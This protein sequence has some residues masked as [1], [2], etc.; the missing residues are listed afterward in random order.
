MDC[1]VSLPCDDSKDGVWAQEELTGGH[2]GWGSLGWFPGGSKM[3]C[4]GTEQLMETVAYSPEVSRKHCLNSTEQRRQSGVG[5]ERGPTRTD[6]MKPNCS[7]GRATSKGLVPK[8]TWPPCPGSDLTSGKK[9]KKC[10]SQLFFCHSQAITVSVHR[11]AQGSVPHYAG[12]FQLPIPG[13]EWGQDL[14]ESGNQPC[15]PH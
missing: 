8:S 6:R 3:L 13:P 15:S 11:H 7:H 10:F 14:G 5:G 1:T 12:W 2:V 9:E 4:P